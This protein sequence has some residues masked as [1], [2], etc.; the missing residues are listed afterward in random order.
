M[1]QT[2]AIK[3]IEHKIEL[4]SKTKNTED[5]NRWQNSTV[6]T[7]INI[8]SESDKRIKSFENIR[9]YHDYGIGG[10]DRFP[11]AKT[12]AEE[13]LNSLIKD[14]QDFGIINSSKETKVGD[15]NFNINQSNTQNQSTNVNIDLNIVLDVLKS[16]LRDYEFEELKEILESKEEPKEKK[17]KF[18]NKI[19]S[20]GADVSS[21]I[22]A[23]LLTNPMVF[24]QLGKMF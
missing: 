3:A 5:F 23:N 12:E 22:L 1:E 7:L 11:K 2:N 20:F 9:S 17:K 24:E 8:Y 6:L 19:K 21:N 10:S 18:F 15:F 4:L 13:T 16:G 14:I